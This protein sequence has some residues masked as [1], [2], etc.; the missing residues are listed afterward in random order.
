MDNL[1]LRTHWSD[2]VIVLNCAD[3]FHSLLFC[4]SCELSVNIIKLLGQI[5]V[6]ILT[7][8]KLSIKQPKKAS[9]LN[10]NAVVNKV[11]N[12]IKL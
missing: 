11:H 10:H 6:F 1:R 5:S 3:V 8:I 9:S 7:S 12:Y 2:V 4:T